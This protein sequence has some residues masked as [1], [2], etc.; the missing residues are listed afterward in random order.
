MGVNEGSERPR[1]NAQVDS[2]FISG[3]ETVNDVSKMPDCLGWRDTSFSRAVKNQFQAQG[4]FVHL[5]G[6]SPGD[7]L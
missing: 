3:G 2:E 5:I 1:S 7:R 4:L 6:N